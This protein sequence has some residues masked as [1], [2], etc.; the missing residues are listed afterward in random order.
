[1]V[2]MEALIR[3]NHPEFGLLAPS[4]F[5][6]QIEQ[7][8]F[9]SEL[10]TWVID[11]AAQQL[12]NWHAQGL[13][14]M[15]ISVNIVPEYFQEPHLLENLKA[16]F[17]RHRVSPEYLEFEVTENA[18]QTDGNLDIFRQLRQ[19]GI[20]IAI[21]DFGTGYSCLAS[22]KQLPL[23]TLKIDKVFIDDVEGNPNTA[24]LLGTIIGLAKALH[25]HLVAEGVETL[26]QALIMH[27]MGCNTIQGYYFSHPVPADAI[28]ALMDYDFKQMT[29]PS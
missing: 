18:I 21:D 8:G 27:G 29:H 17:A 22:L 23:D 19:L 2:S 16:I 1:M 25:Y 4:E 15:R 9:M 28:P 5:L 14:Y 24:L 10:C 13:A 26:K 3:W 6:A 20:K 12:M 11:R 7:Y